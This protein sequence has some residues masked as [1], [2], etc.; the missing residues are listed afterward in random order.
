MQPEETPGARRVLPT[1]A[2]LAVIF[3]LSAAGLRPPA[4]QPASA[5]ATQ[6]SAERAREVLNHLVGDGIPHPTG[7]AANGVVRGRVIDELTKLGYQPEVQTGFSCDD[8]GTCAT[9]KNILARLDGAEPGASVLLS[10]HYDSVPAG[11]G[12][13]D[14]GAG[15]AAVIE[16]AR[17]LKSMPAPRHSIIILIDDGEEAG[18]LGAHAFVTQSPWAKDVRAAVNLEARGTSGPSMMFETGS[19]NYW[20]VKLYSQNAARPATSS[21]FYQ[22][23]KQLPNDTDFTV[24]KASGYQGV[25]FAYIGDV[26]HY[27]TPLDNLEN[28]DPRSLQHHGENALPMI[29]A[30]ANSDLSN[31]PAKEA[32]FFDL[33]ER[34]VV[35]WPAG[36]SFP[37]A[38]VA[39]ILLLFQVGWLIAKNR[40][41]PSALLWGIVNW[42]AI[43][44]TTG[45]LALI[46][47]KILHV[48]G[49]TP[50]NWVAHPLPLQITFWCLAIS[51][52]TVVS[53]AFESRSGF[54]GLWAG[55]WIWWALF[56][57]VICWLTGGIGY[58][59]LV[60]S[61]IAVVVGLP[62]TIRGSEPKNGAWL[63]GALPLFA[64]G[65]VGFDHLI[66]LY[67]GLGIRIL[68]GIALLVALFLSPL[69]PLLASLREP[70]G[71]T[72]FALPGAAITA[73]VLAIFAAVVAPAYSAKAPEHV[74]LQYRQDGDSGKSQWVVYTDSGRL[75]EP[76]RVATN[77][78]RIDKG[79]LPWD[80]S[81][82][83]LADAPHLE[84]A[85][86]T[87]T[88][89]ES[90]ESGGKRQYRALLRSERGAPEAAVFFPPDSGIDQI[91]IQDEP[92][93]HKTARVLRYFNGWDLYRCMTMPTKGVEMQF[94]LPLGK[95]VEV[96][97]LD[98]SYLLPLEGMFVVKSRP[99][100]A[101]SYQQGDVTILTRRVQLNP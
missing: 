47:Q 53:L 56:S 36:W 46:F 57:V 44:V 37:I 62:F 66:L 74:N 10:A 13:S 23:Y 69:A 38:I 96:Y 67:D 98:L 86:P 99:L 14:D 75:P 29:L 4:P 18:L 89:L 24:F 91:R 60:P 52:V 34:R 51:V 21:I 54:W 95:P 1:V 101:T 81:P 25:N 72:R 26:N 35:M 76:I 39:L 33:F 73:T 32:V 17:A 8:F 12:A 9:V 58:V 80:T 48:A 22:V 11:P 85:P 84:M 7:S 63:A 45:V 42:L 55:V 41:L 100:T 5:P 16:I 30:L 59:L 65:I 83:F 19:A 82:A 50:T 97:V 40:L 49:V 3:F 28:A 94:E 92:I 88:I 77:F 31:P 87:F 78:H 20:V 68:A 79:S 64:A 93:P 61:C 27:H 2:I 43:F 15:V 71:F 6:F 90:S 70:K